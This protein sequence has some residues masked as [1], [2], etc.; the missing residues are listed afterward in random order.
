MASPAQS[1][2][3][4]FPPSHCCLRDQHWQS[5]RAPDQE[6]VSA[7]LPRPASSFTCS[8]H[9]PLSDPS[10]ASWRHQGSLNKLV[11]RA[12]SLHKALKIFSIA[13]CAS[14]CNSLI[15]FSYVLN[16][17]TDTRTSTPAHGPH[18]GSY[19]KSGKPTQH[20]GVGREKQLDNTTLELAQ[21]KL[22]P[23]MHHKRYGLPDA[24]AEAYLSS[25]FADVAWNLTS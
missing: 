10:G 1:R 4:A 19:Y 7:S 23:K 13:D 11:G 18:H 5:A 15:C 9:L 14:F 25:S 2:H 20:K 12:S 3:P 6:S 8:Q 24:V 22:L 21:E 17:K 16:P